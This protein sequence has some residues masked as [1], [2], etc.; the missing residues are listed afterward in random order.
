M[1]ASWHFR[2]HRLI[3][4]ANERWRYIRN[5]MPS[6][7][8]GFLGVLPEHMVENAEVSDQ[9]TDERWVFDPEILAKNEGGYEWWDQ[10]LVRVSVTS[11]E[12]KS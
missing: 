8:F 12:G 3:G 4:V 1:L 2:I 11:P 6:D 7:L 9:S 5:S 10:C